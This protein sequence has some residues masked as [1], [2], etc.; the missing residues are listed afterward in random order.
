MPADKNDEQF[1]F[2]PADKLCAEWR[3]DPEF[4]KRADARYAL[5]Q[6][7][8][9]AEDARIARRKKWKAVGAKLRGVWANLTRGIGDG[10]L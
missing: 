9:R 4:A 10:V 8:S 5:L 2:I 6:R 3:K 7:R 1:E